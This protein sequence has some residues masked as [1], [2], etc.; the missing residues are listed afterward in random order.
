[1]KNINPP[2]IGGGKERF[3]LSRLLSFL[4]ILLVAFTMTGCGEAFDDGTGNGELKDWGYV[5][6][7]R[8]ATSQSRAYTFD[9]RKEIAKELVNAI[10]YGNNILNNAYMALNTP[11]LL[12]NLT[13]IGGINAPH[14]NLEELGD[15]SSAPGKKIYNTNTFNW[16]SGFFRST[17]QYNNYCLKGLGTSGKVVVNGGSAFED[18]KFDNSSTGSV[19]S[20]YS[21]TTFDNVSVNITSP[22]GGSGSPYTLYGIMNRTSNRSRSSTDATKNVDELKAVHFGLDM[23]KGETV[24]RFDIYDNK[25]AGAKYIDFYHPKWGYVKVDLAFLTTD[26]IQTYDRITM[27][28]DDNETCIFTKY[29]LENDKSG[30][31]QRKFDCKSKT[32]VPEYN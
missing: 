23:P 11:L 17:I 30:K 8:G 12:D 9:D 31:A 16:G 24:Y 7:Y 5:S 22:N 25:T 20:V 28:F 14:F 15:C 21:E 4:I 19:R 18:E 26:K 13:Q 32:Y 10:D 2:Y 6:R 27:K 29:D 3:S 1:M